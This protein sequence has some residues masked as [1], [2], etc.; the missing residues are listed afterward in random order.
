MIKATSAA[1][2]VLGSLTVLLLAAESPRMPFVVAVV[3]DATGRGVPL[4]ELQ[5]VNN[6]RYYTD[7]NG[8][9][10]F[11]EPGLMDQT[12]FFHIKS[13]GYEFPKDGFGFRGKALA[14]T[15]GGKI[16]LEIKRLNIAERLYRLTGAGIYR[17][18]LLT[19]R[20]APIRQPVLNGQV[21]GSDS[22]VNTLYRGKIYW[23]WGDTNRPSYPLGNFNVPGATSLPP[24]SGGLDPSKGVD[25][26]YFVDDKG[27]AKAMAPLPGSGPTWIHG[28][29]TLNDSAGNEQLFA[30]Y[31]KVR[32]LLEVYERGLARFNDDKQQFEK[33][34]EFPLDAPAGSGGHPFKHTVNGK[35]YVYFA[36]P[37]P[38][39]RVPA[40]PA[41]FKDLARYEAF[42]CLKEGTK[43]DEQEVDRDA[44]GKVHYGWKCNTPVVGPLEQNKLFRSGRLKREE[45][46]LQLQDVDTGKTVFAHA[47]SV[48]W[49]K[50]RG[51]WVMITVES[52]GTSLL[53]EIWFA[54][55]DSPTGPWVYARKIVTHDKYSFYNPK[56]H[57]FFD[58]Q[59]GRVIFFE[60]TYTHSFSGNNEQTPRYDYN[61]IMYKLTLTDP[62]LALP[63]AIYDLSTGGPPDRFS[64]LAANQAMPAGPI[65]FF[66]ADRPAK[67]TMPVYAEHGTDESWALRIGGPP[68]GASAAAP[69]FHAL[70]PDHANPPTTTVP[71]YEFVHKDGKRRA[72]SVESCWSLPDYQR[73]L[74]P[75]CRVWRKP[76]NV[77]DR[78]TGKRGD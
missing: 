24:T 26:Q 28:L 6:I 38:L 12:V 76:G 19:G 3:D 74:R 65:A 8:V 7:S 63:V 33:L 1:V 14:V 56:Q 49:N 16:E 55:A 29:V 69:V 66:A 64:A 20:S 46:L 32:G 9:V 10:A 51:R 61:Q 44:G 40:D 35:E 62:R 50:S 72:Y 47:G 22:V 71:L 41:K 45:A 23:F 43:L 48:C 73:A 58:Q 11:D 34:M 54:E 52:G 36:T 59:D 42:T 78:P 77:W 18:S 60:G 70:P 57:P 17:D 2:T 4:V 68:A 15:P 25:L 39:I 21:L 53:G 27:F 30:A 13:H 37:Y 75:I 5:T 31:M 67:D